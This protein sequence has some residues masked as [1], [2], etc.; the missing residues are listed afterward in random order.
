MPGGT[1]A[2]SRGETGSED[3]F[4]VLGMDLPLH[5]IMGMPL[6][7]IIMGMPMDIIEVMASQQSFIISI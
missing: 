6:H 2:G 3:Y 7:I 5:I 4:A 1:S